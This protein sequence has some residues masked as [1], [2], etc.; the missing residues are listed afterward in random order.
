L[1]DTRK[2][3]LSLNN[4]YLNYIKDNCSANSIYFYL[5]QFKFKNSL[6]KFFALTNN[7]PNAQLVEVKNLVNSITNIQ[8]ASQRLNT[9]DTQ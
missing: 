9:K 7:Y 8:K 4:Y 6:F 5:Y 1:F 3:Y 2:S